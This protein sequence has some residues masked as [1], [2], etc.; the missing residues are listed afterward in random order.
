MK[1]KLLA[2][3]VGADEETKKL[4]KKLADIK[5]ALDESAIVAITDPK[6][7]ITYANKKFCEISKYSAEELLGQTHRIINSGYHPKEFFVNLWRT[8]ASG[9]TWRGEIRNRAK[10]GVFYWVDTTI[11]PLLD[12]RGK[13]YEYVSIRYDIT[14]RKLNEERIRQQAELLNKTVDAILVC[15]LNLEILFWNNSAEKI[16]EWTAEEVLGRDFFEIVCGG[17]RSFYEKSKNDFYETGEFKAE[18]THFTKSGKKLIAESRWTLVRNEQNQ[19]DYILIVNTDV[20]EQKRTEEHLLR[21]QRMESIGTL[22]GGIAHDLNNILSPILMSVDMLQSDP[23]AKEAGEPWISIIK[24]NTER[25]ADLIKQ[26]LTFAR[27]VEGEKILV[28]IRHLI[29]DLSKILRETLPRSVTLKTDIS[30][31]LWTVMGDP[32]QIHQVLMNLCVN[33][34]DA[35]PAGGTLTITAENVVLDEN[36]ARMNFEAEAGRYVLLNV[37]DTGTGM[38]PEIVERIFDPFFTT[39][40]VGKGTGLGLSTALTIVKSHG[41]FI[42]VYSEP[43]KGTK[44]SIYFPAVVEEVETDKSKADSLFPHGAGEL[45]LLVDDEA[46][47]LQIT[48]ATLEKY[49]YKV[50]TALDGTEALALYAQNAGEVAL[51]LTDMMMPFMDGAATIRALRKLNPKIPIIAASGLTSVEQNAEIQNLSINGF[52]SKPYTAQQLLTA[53]ADVLKK[54]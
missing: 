47:I 8:I 33:A 40:E 9:K 17:D 48:K 31:D 24:E 2:T 22:A 32:T 5:Y 54:K 53:V 46:N 52:L 25:G 21:A 1:E 26:V 28:Q 36:Y 41:G 50:L 35:M 16:Y 4:L 11:V 42:N 7:V 51:V 30:P 45:V 3:A 27:G 14:E 44:F 10:D 19:P 20:T 18:V 43:G 37:A 29:K 23:K 13:P 12:E 15:N 39:K 49:G 34:R 6:G 38:T